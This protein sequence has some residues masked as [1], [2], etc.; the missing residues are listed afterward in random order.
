MSSVREIAQ[1]AGVSITTVSRV[2]N[3][4]PRVSEQARRRVL[5]A[6]NESRYQPTVGRK[7]TVN[8]ALLYT[9]PMAVGSAFDA[10]LMDG[11]TG[12]MEEFGYD[13]M[14]LDGSRVRQPDETY[15][16]VFMRKGIRGVI[17]RSSISSRQPAIDIANEGFPAVVLGDRFDHPTMAFVGADSAAASAEAIDHLIGL[18]H[19]EIGVVTNVEDDCDHLDRL[20]GFHQ[21]MEKAGLKHDKSRVFR[22]P[23]HRIGGESFI[24]RFV[25]MPKKSRPTALYFVDP[26]SGFAALNRAQ[27]LGVRV[28]DELSIVGFDDHEWRFMA[29]PQMT[30]VCQDAIALGRSAFITLNQL[31]ERPDQPLATESKPAWLEVHGTTGPPATI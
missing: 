10:A 3:N 21:A 18:G 22:S 15:S 27:K 8:I 30:A 16:Q 4:H 23:A 5:S 11:M 29:L 12:S 9:G 6:A 20:A 28:P 17:L 25:S 26:I 2:L 14:V 7:S 24:N 19:R 13:L 1:K 31:I